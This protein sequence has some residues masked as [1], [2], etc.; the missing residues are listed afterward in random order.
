[1]PHWTLGAE[2]PCSRLWQMLKQLPVLLTDDRIP[3]RAEGVL[4]WSSPESCAKTGEDYSWIMGIIVGDSGQLTRDFPYH[5]PGVRKP[6]GK[7][8]DRSTETLNL[9]SYFCSK[10]QWT[11]AKNSHWT[12]NLQPVYMRKTW[13]RTLLIY[14]YSSSV[15]QPNPLLL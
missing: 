2:A 7:T 12:P 15:I 4:Q 3:P 1:M 9:P 8:G 10:M 5:N 11:K 14:I 6:L 13:W